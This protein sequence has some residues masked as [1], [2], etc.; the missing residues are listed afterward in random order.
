[1]SLLHAM[2]SALHDES[3]K[4][5]DAAPAENCRSYA[6]GI[7][8]CASAAYARGL[9]NAHYLRVRKGRDMALPVR[10]R[11]RGVAC[12]DCGAATDAKGGFGRC[13]KH[14]RIRRRL[15]LKSA[16]VAFHGGTCRRCGQTHASRVFDFHHTGE[17]TGSPSDMFG[18]SSLAAI[19]AE[20]TACELLCAN[21]HRME[22]NDGF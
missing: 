15:L 18:R 9:C 4:H 6:C 2:Q 21:C 3:R 14:Y 5:A 16:A 10:N 22:H 13:A 19:A 8:G 12:I 11:K 17:K 7:A 20:L 1:M